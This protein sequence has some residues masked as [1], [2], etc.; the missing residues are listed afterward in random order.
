MTLAF[1]WDQKKAE[2]NRRKHRVDFDEAKTVF[3][4]PL[5][6]TI[7]DPEHSADECR[8]VDIG[9]SAR[10]RLL[11]VVYTERRPNKIR[12]IS[13]RKATKAEQREYEQDT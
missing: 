10:R 9:L 6:L 2:E 13:S 11:V 5:S 4:D 1:E 8:Y 3:A 7:E 12:I